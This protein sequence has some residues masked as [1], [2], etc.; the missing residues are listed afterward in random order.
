MSISSK[1]KINFK[2]L[3]SS[4]LKLPNF[5]EIHIE[6]ISDEDKELNSSFK[7]FELSELDLNRIN[8][9]K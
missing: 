2:D 8:C 6:N 3:C 7:Y 9:L 1:T 4:K 5:G